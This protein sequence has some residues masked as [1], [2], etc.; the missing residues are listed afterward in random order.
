MA[1]QFQLPIT[2]MY[3]HDAYSLWPPGAMFMEHGH[4]IVTIL[5]QITV[6]ENDTPSS[7]SKKVRT[8]FLDASVRPISAKKKK[9]SF[10][11]HHLIA[12]VWLPLSYVI[13]WCAYTWI[14]G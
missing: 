12:L 8:A 3:I 9:T 2:P 10:N 5:P 13:C 1:K 14:R 7:L 4:V 11:I 6:A